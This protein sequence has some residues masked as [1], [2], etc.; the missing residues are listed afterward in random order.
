MTDNPSTVEFI[1]D[2]QIRQ[3]QNVQALQPINGPQVVGVDGSRTPPQ[4]S[5]M[6]S[7]MDGEMPRPATI[8]NDFY[9]KAREI[10]RDPTIRM[11]RELSMAPLLM[12]EWEYVA[13]DDAPPGAKELVESVMTQMRLPLLR[14]SLAGMCDY[15][16]QPYE[17]IAEQRD[18]GVSV[19]RV[20]PL[21]QDLTHILVNAADGTYFGL[22]QTPTVG[23]RIGWVYLLDQQSFV[24]S[25]D[26][27]GTNWYGEPTLRSLEKTYDESEVVN[28]SSRKY[29]AK[30]A[31][32][33]WVIYYPLGTSDYGGVTKD[34]GVIAKELLQQAEA[35]GGI[36]VP[37]SVVSSL[38]SMNAAM[39]NSEASQWKI[40]LLSDSGKGQQPFTDRQKY[41]DILKVRAFGFP[42]RSILEGQFGTKADA[43]AH[44]DI[45]VSNLEVRHALV[46]LQYSLKVVNLVLAWNYGPQAKGKVWIKAS[47]LADD[48]KSFFRQL[49]LALIANPQGFMTEMSA[50]DMAQLRDKLGLPEF[51]APS[52]SADPWAIM[53]DPMTGQ[54][55]MPPE[56]ATPD[57]AAQ[58]GAIPGIG[59]A[60]DPEQ[61]P[62]SLSLAD[63]IDDAAG[64][65]SKP[66][67][68]QREAG[69]YR[70]GH[71]T[72]HGLRIAIETPRGEK[73]KKKWP[74]L[75]AHYG[76]F[77]GSVGADGDQVDVFIGPKPATEVAFVANMKGTN[78]KFDEHKVVLGFKSADRARECLVEAYGDQE[79]RIG[80][81]TAMTIPMLKEW[82]SLPATT[83]LSFDPDQPRAKDGRWEKVEAIGRRFGI[84]AK[85]VHDVLSTHPDELARRDK[86]SAPSSDR[87]NAVGPTLDYEKHPLGTAK[88][89]S[90]RHA[91]GETDNAYVDYLREFDP[92]T[93]K[94]SEHEDGIG[95]S[96]S[97]AKYVEWAKAGHQAP[98]ISVF[99]SSNG[100]GD[101]VST[102][103]RR[104]LAA[105]EAGT[106]LTG[107]HG[108][109]NKETGLPLRYGDLKKAAAE[110]KL[111][112]KD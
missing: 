50:V 85:A 63:E 23:T 99:D 86:Y 19:P 105:R 20:K 18:D 3:V 84:P 22:R 26:V 56:Y 39:A 89:D 57:P 109:N 31:G 98:P 12:A 112:L 5:S 37:R 80:K 107:W 58:P 36:A 74:K 101:H 11:V 38:D 61:H 75:P 13:A 25:Q 54:L 67:K 88:I 100:N 92:Q 95:K 71:V 90:S 73:R 9:R 68:A 24:I 104:V 111:N 83:A 27:E 77:K 40:E 70:K 10:R 55:L 53:T 72:V 64:E 14:T 60:F 29:D 62:T 106:K 1:V 66:T 30:I 46:C 65:V 16:W 59:F 93:L 87:D 49:Y 2:Q 78:G 33:H 47:P 7:P 15:G 17:V 32:T 69:N 97:V 43:E 94:T 108:V 110:L 79:H 52:G 44:A 28:K 6:V 8:G 103:R 82:L 35:V 48:K 51:Q 34:N 4:I 45:A 41:L 42:E 96:G 91:T 21:L 76:Y 81:L 102:N